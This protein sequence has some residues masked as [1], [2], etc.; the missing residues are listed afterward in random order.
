MVFVA[1]SAFLVM[2]RRL[3]A[4][5]RGR[6]RYG[7][8]S[9]HGPTNSRRWLGQGRCQ[10]AGS[11]SLWVPEVMSLTSWGSPSSPGGNHTKGI[12]LREA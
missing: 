12:P 11:A 10:V 6:S 7:Y 2:D 8:L 1:K 3:S 5:I 9:S 4:G